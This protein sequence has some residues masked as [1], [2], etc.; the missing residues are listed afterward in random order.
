MASP[1]ELARKALDELK[2]LQAEVNSLK[3]EVGQYDFLQVVQRLAVIEAK[4]AQLEKAQDE[5]KQIAVL[6]D[7]VSELKKANEESG[8]RGWQFVYIAA[9]AGLALVSSFAVQ[10]VFFLLKK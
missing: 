2:D 7:R 10:L 9:G 4:L 1:T 3:K 5:V 6:A 8:K